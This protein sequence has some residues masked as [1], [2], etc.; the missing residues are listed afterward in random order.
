MLLKGVSYAHKGCI[1]VI[2]NTAKTVVSIFL[3]YKITLFYFNIFSNVIY[4][5]DGKAEFST[6]ISHDLSQIIFNIW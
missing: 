1:Y 2:N 5:C 3:Q 6:A 4:V